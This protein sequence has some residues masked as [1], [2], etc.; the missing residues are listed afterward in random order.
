[1]S[2]EP[3]IGTPE[4]RHGNRPWLNDDH[5]RLLTLL[6]VPH[7]KN[8]TCFNYTTLPGDD[9]AAITDHFELDIRTFVQ[10]EKNHEVF[11]LENFT[12]K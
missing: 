7:D 9:V 10:D 3:A 11:R 8:G 6:P 2:C 1:V 4:N 5:R 12:Y